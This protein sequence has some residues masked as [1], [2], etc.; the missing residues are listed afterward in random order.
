M[1]HILL[2]N[3]ST[4]GSILFKMEILVKQTRTKLGKVSDKMG[5]NGEQEKW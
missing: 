3:I 4:S 5:G 2:A 1:E